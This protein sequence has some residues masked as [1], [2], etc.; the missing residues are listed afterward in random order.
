MDTRII[1]FP[2]VI[3]LAV[4]CYFLFKDERKKYFTIFM[5]VLVIFYMV[6]VFFRYILNDGFIWVINGGYYNDMY[7]ETTDYLQSFLRWGHYLSYVVFAMAIF[8]NSRLFK[9]ISI[10][11]CLPFAILSGIFY[12][13]FMAYFMAD[14]RGI[15]TSFA[16]RE[17]YFS[18]ELIIAMLIPLLFLIVDRHMFDFKNKTEWKN[19]LVSLPFII[20]L[21]VPVYVPQSLIG[22]TQHTTTAMTIGNFIWLFITFLEI[23]VL[24]ILFRFKDK[25]QRYMLC[26]FLALALFM[27]Y[28]SMYLMGFTIQRLPFQLCNLGAYFFVFALIIKNRAFFNFTFIANV[29]G[30]L[31]AMI[32][33]D[34]SGGFAGF[35]NIH[36]LIEHMQVLVIPI[37]CMLLRIFPR[38]DKSALKHLLIGFT[39]YFAFCWISGTII[40]AY[41]VEGGYGMVNYF[42]IFDLEKAFGYFPFL[43]FTE[44]IHICLFGKF[45]IWPVFQLT[46]YA[47]FLLLCILFYFLVLKFYDILDDH[48]EL[49]KARIDLYEKITGKKSKAKRDY[50]LE[51]DEE[52][53]KNNKSI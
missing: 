39:C 22:Y 44:N 41:A 29:V 1:L 24:Y 18:V 7:Y 8:F 34:T 51:E 4:A 27:H 13:D 6:W 35:W 42:Y 45:D 38:V 36:F 50:D 25:R 40:N 10:F 5:K 26:M 17:F 9:N 46:V 52:Y 31:I 2:L 21:L 37:L 3:L 28:N 15:E 23:A 33:P 14:G 32:M 43:T 49:R 16:F 47:G 48:F 30:T 20:L 53:V 11:V 19:F 12:Y